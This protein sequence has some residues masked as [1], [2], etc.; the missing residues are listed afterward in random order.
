[1]ISN[2]KE[3][4]FYLKEDQRALGPTAYSPFW[5]YLLYKE[6]EIFYYQR[7]LRK[8]EFLYAINR[9]IITEIIFRYLYRKYKIRSL[10]FG[11]TIPLNTFGPGLSIAHRGFIVV[12]PEAKIGSNC[13]IHPGTV[14]GEKN[15]QSPTIGNNVYIGP[16]AKIFGGITI[17][18]NVK[19]GANAVVNKSISEPGVTVVGIPAKILKKE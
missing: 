14:I 19:I 8:V 6:G 9:N 16:G 12:N 3:Y 1:M 11:F 15:N 5:K 13:R 4:I 2:K 17:A 7:L 18:N 10:K